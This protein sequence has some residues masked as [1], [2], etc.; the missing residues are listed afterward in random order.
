MLVINFKMIF[1][2]FY[3]NLFVG[4]YLGEWCGFFLNN[5]YCIGSRSYERWK[6]VFVNNLGRKYLICIFMVVLLWYLI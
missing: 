6:R 3:R 4:W 5:E 1:V 2:I